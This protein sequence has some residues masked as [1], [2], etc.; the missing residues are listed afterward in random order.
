MN[1]KNKTDALKAIRDVALKLQLIKSNSLE[2]DQGLDT[3]IALARYEFDLRDP[4][5]IEK[6]KRS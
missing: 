3:I 1:E 4:K 5:E 6:F 2:I